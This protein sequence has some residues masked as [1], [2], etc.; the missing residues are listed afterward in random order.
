MVLILLNLHPY[1]QPYNFLKTPHPPPFWTGDL[2]LCK[3]TE[4]TSIELMFKL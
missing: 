3:D 4:D 1:F 2:F